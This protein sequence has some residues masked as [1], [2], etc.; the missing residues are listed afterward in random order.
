MSS[1]FAS[2]RLRPSL[3]T[4]IQELGWSNCTPVQ[5]SVI[6]V[7]LE[8]Q[9]VAGLAQTGTGK[10]GA[11]LVPLIERIVCSMNPPETLADPED[12]ELH[13]KRAWAD[14]KRHNFLL[15][16]VPT[17]EL[18]EQVA[19]QAT[20]LGTASNL[21]VAA[22]Y[23]G[24]G[25]DKQKE[26]LR[27]GFEIIV[28]TPGR[29]I[30]LY[31]EHLVDLRQVRAICFDEADRMF[32]MGFKDD[33]KFL[34]G[35]IPR[36]RQ[37]L[38][39]SATLNFDVLNTAYQFGAHPVEFNISRDQ[40]KAENVKD[41]IFHVGQ[42]EKAR[43]LLSLFKKTNPQQAIVFTNFKT[44]V[45]RLAKFLG[46]NG[47]SAVGISSLLTQ[48]QR[49]RVMEQ[50]K[51]AEHPVNVLV[52]TDVAA[53]G[54][55]IQGVD[56]VINYDLPD[57]P[58]NYVH[59]IGRTGR[60]GAEGRAFSFVSDRDVDALTRVEAYLHHKVTVGWM[61][62]SELVQDFK[63]LFHDRGREGRPYSARPSSGGGG[64]FAGSGPRG[65]GRGEGRRD[66]PRDGS[67]GGGRDG[68]PRR[69]GRP[70]GARGAEQRG[71]DS[72][73]S[74]RASANG[75]RPSVEGRPSRRSEGGG[76]ARHR[77]RMNG[78][79]HA[80]N[81]GPRSQGGGSGTA[82]SA[83]GQGGRAQQRGPLGKPQPN[84]GRPPR[85]GGSSARPGSGKAA[86]SIGQR[87]SSFFKR[88]I[89]G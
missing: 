49:T 86:P 62:D 89:G 15:I 76:E 66:G 31:K 39:F 88:I 22:V 82:Q 12:V 3:Q 23:G 24:V 58:E 6:P 4:S 30:D 78:G 68:G 36:E 44:N 32:D 54:L 21:R 50:Y 34:L 51:D 46:D 85:S 75:S 77:D 43:Y 41:E 9:D 63:P 27:E 33:M 13:K 64:R 55:D 52:A 60:A 67:R 73:G 59:R 28:A 56:L 48:A 8:G 10:T 38:V 2:Y 53:R 5:S 61:E 57:D 83:S 65:G 42:E 81:R 20:K 29:L 40:P 25:Y 37:F 74:P 18:A 45:D 35:R 47:V 84:K 14:W 7:I 1:D 11:F 69:G 16:L 17:R 70:D 19:E 79:R 26:A 87:V 80:E 71:P 72:G